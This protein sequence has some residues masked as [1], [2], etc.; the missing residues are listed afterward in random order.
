[1]AFIISNSPYNR[2]EMAVLSASPVIGGDTP[3]TTTNT[4]YE[5]MKQ[6]EQG[7]RLEDDYYLVCSPSGGTP[8]NIDEKYNISSPPA[9]P[10]LLPPPPVVP[11]TYINVN[12]A[13]EGVYESIP[14]DK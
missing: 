13:K 12:T 9:S 6:R 2:L 14:V 10:Q 7:R 1:M 11:P 4:A 5:V 8:L 3:K